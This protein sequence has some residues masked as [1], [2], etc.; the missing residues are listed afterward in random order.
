MDE[1]ADI[2]SLLLLVLL[3]VVLECFFPYDL[4]S[5]SQPTF[6]LE[7][8]KA[9]DGRNGQTYTACNGIVFDIS[10]SPYDNP[11]SLHHL[12]KGR[13]ASLALANMD[14]TSNRILSTRPRL[15]KLT[16]QAKKNL[17]EWEEVYRKKYKIVGKMDYAIAVAF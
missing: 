3:Y 2:L 9:Y 7:D 16:V 13:D 10:N 6:T 1:V 12:L 17:K 4:S 5:D 14:F 15:E 8:L 11:E